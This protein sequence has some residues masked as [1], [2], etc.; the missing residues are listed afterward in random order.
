[1][2]IR[3]CLGFLYEILFFKR[4]MRQAQRWVGIISG[5]Q[6]ESVKIRIFE[7]EDKSTQANLCTAH[8]GLPTKY[9]FLSQSKNF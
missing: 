2:Q 1:M 4:E 7:P 9:V 6:I 8:Q 3:Y 5:N